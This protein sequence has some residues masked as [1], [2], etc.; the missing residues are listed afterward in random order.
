MAFGLPCITLGLAGLL[1][2]AM[3]PGIVQRCAE[4]SWLR[5]L[6]G[7]SYGI[8]VFHML[9][10]NTFISIEEKLFGHHGHGVT[11]AGLFLV[12]AVGSVGMAWISFHFF[13]TPFLTL[14]NRFTTRSDRPALEAS[15]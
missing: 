4:A 6:G 5:W 7:I 3:R 13:E 10:L 8:Y 9:F 14:K 1:V 12:A 2:L 11:T 15:R